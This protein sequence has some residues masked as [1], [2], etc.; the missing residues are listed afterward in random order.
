MKVLM[1]IPAYNE[2]ENILNTV[3][4]IKN[5]KKVKLDY[6]VI[7]DGS[8]DNTKKVLEDNNI[9]YINLCNNLGIGAAV[10]TGYKYAYYNNYD[11]AIQYDGDGQHD[12]NYVNRLIDGI[13]KDKY[14]MVIGSRFVG[15]ESEFKSTMARRIGIKLISIIIKIFTKKRILDTTSGYRAVNKELIEEF[16]KNYVFDYPE[17]I[18]SMKILKKGYKVNEIPVNMLERKF[19][20]SSINFHKSIYYMLNVCLTLILIG[21]GGS[22]ND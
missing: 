5:Y 14:D 9:N 13:S 20:V 17:P 6:V 18:S 4:S 8:K 7:N 12:I 1:I 3:K 22:K 19:G 10:Q 21:I 11:I 15:H 16:A 2:E